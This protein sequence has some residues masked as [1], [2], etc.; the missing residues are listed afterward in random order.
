MPQ[1]LP[2]L[3]P[4]LG[5]ALRPLP[6]APLSL[7]LG[8]VTRHLARRH[9]VILRRLGAHGGCRFLI[10]ATDVPAVLLLVPE[11]LALSAHRRQAPPR[12]DA[13][14]TGRLSAFLAMMHGTED[15]DALFFSRDLMVEG[16]TAAVLALRNALDDAELDLGRDLAA[17]AGPLGPGIGRLVQRAERLT[18]LALRRAEGPG[19]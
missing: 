11:R 4:L 16:D 1:T 3:P 15:G 9:P 8:R 19:A 18:G 5:L 6:L 17:L 10:D 14:I 13:R 12:H 2:G 7:V